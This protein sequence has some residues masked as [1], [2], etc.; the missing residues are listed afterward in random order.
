MGQISGGL[1]N[2]IR[3][4][5]GGRVYYNTN[6]LIKKDYLLIMKN[7]YFK[8]KIRVNTDIPVHVD[9]EP[10]LQSPCAITILKSALKVIKSNWFIVEVYSLIY[11]NLIDFKATMLKKSKTK[12]KRRNT[13][14]NINAPIAPNNSSESSGNRAET[15]PVDPEGIRN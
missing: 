15:D 8:I 11:F 13:E 10:W 9:G 2:A 6:D 1:S 4:A 12:M 14:P 5:Q 7:F 3:L